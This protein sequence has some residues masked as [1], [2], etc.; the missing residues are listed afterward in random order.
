M[1]GLVAV[2]LGVIYLLFVAFGIHGVA[3]KGIE[4]KKCYEMVGNNQVVLTEYDGKFLVM[5]CEIVNDILYIFNDDYVFVEKTEK[6]LKLKKYRKVLV[7][8]IE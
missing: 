2:I 6:P 4:D 5:D 7:E 1:G 8:S 3:I